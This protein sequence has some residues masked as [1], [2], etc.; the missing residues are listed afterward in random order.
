MSGALGI[1]E[2]P[3]RRL[4]PVH[5]LAHFDALLR[6]R[7]EAS[8]GRRGRDF[9][10]VGADRPSYRV[11][12]VDGGYAIGRIDGAV[13]PM[14]SIANVAQLLEHTALGHAMRQGC[15]FTRGH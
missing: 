11:C 6:R 8:S 13:P 14:P 10:V 12:L 4:R 7:R 15:L 1:R 5:D 3:L 2:L 9:V